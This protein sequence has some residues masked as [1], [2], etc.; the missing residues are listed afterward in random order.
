MKLTNLPVFSNVI[1]FVDG[2]SGYDMLFELRAVSKEY[3]EFITHD[4]SMHNVWYTLL[5]RTTHFKLKK[6]YWGEYHDL[7]DCYPPSKEASDKGY[8]ASLSHLTGLNLKEIRN[9]YGECCKE[10][11]YSRKISGPHPVH[12]FRGR[13]LYL[14][15]QRL[16]WSKKKRSYWSVSYGRKAEKLEKDLAELIKRKNHFS[17]LQVYYGSLPKAPSFRKIKKTKNKK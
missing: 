11:H 8:Q 13:D 12:G 6:Y 5:R 2:P 16:M 1:S 15:W 7:V 10:L 3:N 9:K 14:E 4:D 17:A